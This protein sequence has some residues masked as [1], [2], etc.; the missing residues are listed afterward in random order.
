[1]K[2][3]ETNFFLKLTKHKFKH[4]LK[5]NIKKKEEKKNQS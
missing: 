2:K 4:I 5:K 1:M 3:H